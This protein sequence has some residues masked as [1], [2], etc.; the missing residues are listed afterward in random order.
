[1]SFASVDTAVA[2]PEFEARIRVDV[3]E[4]Q[5]TGLSGTQS[6]GGGR[7]FSGAFAYDAMNAHADQALA[8]AGDVAAGTGR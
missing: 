7:L 6:F 4:G 3:A 2:S 8:R 5:R 1:M